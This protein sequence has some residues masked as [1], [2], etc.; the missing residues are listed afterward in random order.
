MK[1]DE[2]KVGGHR[3]ALGEDDQ[4]ELV[5]LHLGAVHLVIRFDRSSGQIRIALDQCLDRVGDHLLHPTRHEQEPL[6]EL[7]QLILV[8]PIGVV[9]LHGSLSRTCP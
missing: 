6:A 9:L 7:S 1:R 2:A 3:L 4:A 8:L 5:D